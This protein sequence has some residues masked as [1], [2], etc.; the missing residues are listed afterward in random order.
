MDRYLYDYLVDLL[1][2]EFNIKNLQRITNILPKPMLSVFVDVPGEIAFARKGEYDPDY[3]NWRRTAY[4]EIFGV[5]KS[6]LILDNTKEL[7]SNID[8]LSKKFEKLISE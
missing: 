4:L 6:V 5:T 8:L 3:L 2:Q 7:N 1:D